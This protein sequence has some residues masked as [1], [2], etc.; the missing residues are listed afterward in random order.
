MQH[1]KLA[2]S[3]KITLLGELE[4]D[5][6]HLLRSAHVATDKERAFRYFVKAHQARELRRKVQQ[7]WLDT[8]ELDWCV[9]KSSARLKWL[10]EEIA[11]NDMELFN[12]IENFADDL[13]SFALNTDLSGCKSCNDDKMGSSLQ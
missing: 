9:V 1:D 4:H 10:N 12:E 11:D 6:H 13:L 3:D 8:D 2:I 5:R 7:R